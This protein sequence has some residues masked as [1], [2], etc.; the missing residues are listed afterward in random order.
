MAK[1]VLPEKEEATNLYGIVNFPKCLFT[2]IFA[3]I[4][5]LYFSSRK[6][7]TRKIL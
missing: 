2:Y 3:L 7:D 6:A 1:T 4:F 5:Y